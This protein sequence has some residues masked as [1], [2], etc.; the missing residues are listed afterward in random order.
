MRR[1]GGQV[2]SVDKTVSGL[3]F[4]IAITGTPTFAVNGVGLSLST[5]DNEDGTF[6]VIVYCLDYDTTFTGV[7]L[8]ISGNVVIGSIT[9]IV[10]SDH[11]GVEVS[12]VAITV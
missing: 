7:F 1:G 3:E 9:N 2:L 4:T 11:D 5:R 12:D 6:N 10:G 8:T